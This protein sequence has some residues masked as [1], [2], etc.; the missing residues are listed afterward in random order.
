MP[1]TQ[2]DLVDVIAATGVTDGRLI[3][4]FRS[5]PRADFVPPHLAAEAYDDLPLPIPHDQVTTQP[6]LSAHMIQALELTASSRVLE[7]GTGYGF[8]TALIARLAAHVTSIGRWPDLAAQARAHL[9]GHGIGNVDVVTGDG[10]LGVPEAAPFDAIVV[11]AAF[12]EVPEPLSAQ[13]AEGG[14]LVQPIGPGGDE[15]VT[16]F[17]KEGGVL[18]RHHDVVPAR[19]VRLIGAAAFPE[20]GAGDGRR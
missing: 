7:V 20:D 19:F 13:L 2:E 8:Q 15:V 12:P 9:A 14:R 16:C 11:S 1:R 17:R 18:R 4:A 10:S 5:I 6:S 3:A